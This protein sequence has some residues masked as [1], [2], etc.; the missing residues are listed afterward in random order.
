LPGEI[1]SGMVPLKFVNDKS[2]KKVAVPILRS[3]GVADPV[4]L[5]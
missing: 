2:T 5:V 3:K 1:P 4:R